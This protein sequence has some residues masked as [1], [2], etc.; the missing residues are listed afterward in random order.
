MNWEIYL[1]KRKFTLSIGSQE[2]GDSD[3]ESGMAVESIKT[4][5]SSYGITKLN[6]EALQ[7]LL[8]DVCFR[9]REISQ[10]SVCKN[11]VGNWKT[12]LLFSS[13]ILFN[14]GIWEFCHFLMFQSVCK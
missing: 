6:D 8:D 11:L 9:L 3:G 2:S 13:C 4:I 14:P 5:A 10:V 1:P 7:F 12:C